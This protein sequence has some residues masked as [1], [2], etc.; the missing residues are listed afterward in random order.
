MLTKWPVALLSPSVNFLIAD[1]C[2]VVVDV[3]QVACRLLIPFS[4][5]VKLVTMH[6][7]VHD[8]VTLHLWMVDGSG[9]DSFFFGEGE[10]VG[11]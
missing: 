10:F 7:T 9:C 4:T 8:T 11:H 6:G 2:R 1:R 3:P 5:C